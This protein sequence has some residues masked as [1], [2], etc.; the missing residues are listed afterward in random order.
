MKTFILTMLACLSF[1]FILQAQN[2]SFI[3]QQKYSTW[4]IPN[5]G[6][7]GKK[8]LLYE[9]RDTA[10]ILSNSPWN[11][12]YASGNYTLSSVNIK[13]M[14]V[15]KVRKQGKGLA[16][17]I[18]GVSGLAVGI[19]LSAVFEN[20]LMHNTNPVGFLFGGF[21]LGVIPVIVSTGAGIG[22]GAAFATKVT[23]PIN[24]NQAEYKRAKQELNKY[25]MIK[26]FA[27]IKNPVLNLPDLTFSKLK[28]TVVDIDGNT[29]Q[30]LALGGQVWTD[31][32]L[33][34]THYSNGD[35]IKEVAENVAWAKTVQGAN[36][37]YM[38]DT[39]SISASGR[40]YNWNAVADSR[41]LCPKG[42][43]VPSIS[44]WTSLVTC[45]GGETE[46]GN[47]IKAGSKRISDNQNQSS[48]KTNPFA[49]PCG[50]RFS[51]GEFS[52]EKALS[53][54][55]WSSSPQDSTAAMSLRLV[56]DNGQIFFTGSSNSY[57]LPV[58]CLRN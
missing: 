11:K 4:V 5:P 8:G 29:Y 27:M 51:N 22:I 1:F 18:G 3:P 54:Q 53:Y 13:S 45:L 7:K 19:A 52:S 50:F 57:G 30:T 9:V 16:M 44:E 17:L 43:H 35:A 58:R 21:M 39:G 34:V 6:F 10:V 42:W 2:P 32:N 33:L 56:Q 14:H 49:N 36:C 24:G 28:D 41:G 31:R 40:L 15:L 46:A 25:A 23:I 38:N 48:E 12:D 55:W 47:K 26:N 37:I 20:Y